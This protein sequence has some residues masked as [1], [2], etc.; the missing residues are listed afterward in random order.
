MLHK[1]AIIFFKIREKWKRGCDFKV[2]VQF[3]FNSYISLRR[4]IFLFP[5]SQYDIHWNLMCVINHYLLSFV[6]TMVDM[7]PSPL[8]IE[9]QVATGN[10]L[11][12][13][14]LWSPCA[15]VNISCRSQSLIS[16]NVSGSVCVLQWFIA[17]FCG[18]QSHVIGLRE[19][20]F[21]TRF[22]V[23]VPQFHSVRFNCKQK[24]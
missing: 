5:T 6:S 18:S 1:F 9:N 8:D 14:W 4:V 16:A 17:S 7:L 24:V 12:N 22:V 10:Q 23:L 15:T 19:T 20:L 2:E 13:K 21:S 11:L 3:K